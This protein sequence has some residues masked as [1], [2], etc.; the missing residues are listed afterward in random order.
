MQSEICP[1]G[2]FIDLLSLDGCD[3]TMIGSN[4]VTGAAVYFDGFFYIYIYFFYIIILHLWRSVN[5]HPTHPFDTAPVSTFIHIRN[6]PLQDLV[7][8]ARRFNHRCHVKSTAFL[9]T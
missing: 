1:V 4:L 8:F 6:D 7:A 9:P 5:T 3:F 2:L